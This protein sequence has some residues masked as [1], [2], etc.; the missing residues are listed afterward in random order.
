M[1]ENLPQNNSP[2][3]YSKWKEL[4]EL[5]KTEYFIG[6]IPYYTNR[7][8]SN[9]ETPWYAEWM[10][11]FDIFDTAVMVCWMVKIDK[12]DPCSSFWFLKLEDGTWA[13]GKLGASY[14]T[15]LDVEEMEDNKFIIMAAISLDTDQ[16]L[17]TRF[18]KK[19][20]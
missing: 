14:D 12:D 2:P 10:M 19:V 16:G 7:V 1:E 15:K 5:R 4:R 6:R 13:R 9:M 18:I 11:T 20:I 8:Y 17:R 3:D